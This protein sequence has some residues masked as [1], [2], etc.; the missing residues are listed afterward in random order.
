LRVAIARMSHE[1]NTFSCVETHLADFNPSYGHEIFKVYGNTRTELGGFLKILHHYDIDIVPTLA[2][3]A[4]PSGP[5]VQ[6]DYGYICQTIVDEGSEGN[7]D[8]MLLS[9]HGAMVAQGVTEAEGTLLQM[10]RHSLGTSIPIICTLDLHAL[11]SDQIISHVDAV[12]GYDTNPHVDQFE[13]GVEAAECMVASLKERCHPVTAFAKLPMMPPTINMRTTEGPM[14]DL[15]K[16][17]R[18]LEADP[19][20]LNVSIFGGF[21]YADVARV[22]SSIVVVTENNRE[23]AQNISDGL[24]STMWERRSD[25]LKSLISVED[26]VHRAQSAVEGPIILADVSDNPGGG[27]PGDG[28][29]ILQQ[30]LKNGVK[31]VGF[32]IIKDPEAVD[33]AMN[34][35]IGNRFSTFIGGKTDPHHGQP[36]QVSGVVTTLTDGIFI[37]KAARAG[38]RVNVGKTAVIDAAGIEIILTERSHAP[39]DPE[40]FRRHGIEPFDKKVLVLKSR[41][42]FRAAYEPH[43]KEVIEVDAPGITSP[44]LGWFTFHHIPRP[45]WPLKGD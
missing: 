25:F 26:A 14:V 32:A 38:M 45:M 9:L 11:V 34:V 8:G 20:V 31:N 15:F 1:T 13:R 2:A 18:A 27:A 43:A 6:E 36:I 35:G 33:H 10:L 16:Q 21:P 17:A 7:P 41:G 28:T 37:N 4:T 3:S 30:L 42:H 12:F 39:N 22:G 5:L 23:L 19:Q 24:G 40:I 29:V 44:N